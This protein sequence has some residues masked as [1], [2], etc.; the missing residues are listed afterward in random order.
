MLSTAEPLDMDRRSRRARAVR[1]VRDATKPLFKRGLRLETLAS[2][3]AHAE[4]RGG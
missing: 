1:G 4:G 2:G 3:A